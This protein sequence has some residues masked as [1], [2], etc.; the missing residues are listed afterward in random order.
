M[1]QNKHLM[2]LRNRYIVNR[3]SFTLAHSNFFWIDTLSG[4][5]L[6]AKVKLDTEY[7]WPQ[8][9][10]VLSGSLLSFSMRA[11]YIWSGVPSKN[12]PQPDRN[13]VSPFYREWKIE[14]RKK[15][16]AYRYKLFYREFPAFA[17]WRCTYIFYGINI[18]QI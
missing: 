18:E 17:T 15:F 7:S 4:S 14:K 2:M 8:K 12:F 13:S 1:F 6:R 9:T 11:A 16:L 5:T 3:Y 10:L